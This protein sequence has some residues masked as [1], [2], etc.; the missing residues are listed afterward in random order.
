MD[1][2]A[3]ADWGPGSPAWVIAL[4]SAAAACAFR[5]TVLKDI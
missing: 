4:V 2:Y 5:V 1:E 3:C